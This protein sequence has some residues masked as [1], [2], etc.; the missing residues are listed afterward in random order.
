MRCDRLARSRLSFGDELDEEEDGPGIAASTA[1]RRGP[2]LRTYCRV[3]AVLRRPTT[4][5]VIVLQVVCQ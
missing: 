4:A 5:P 3:A 1:K 2:L